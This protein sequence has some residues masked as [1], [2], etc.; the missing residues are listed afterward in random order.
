MIP[1]NAKPN[2]QTL[3]PRRIAIHK[4]ANKSAFLELSAIMLLNNNRTPSHALIID[5]SKVREN[6]V[7]LKVM[8]KQ[9]VAE[10]KK[11]IEK[12]PRATFDLKNR[13]ENSFL[14]S[15]P[16]LDQRNLDKHRD[17]NNYTKKLSKN[18]AD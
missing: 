15:R 5:N 7:Q 17:F 10:L 12:A 11:L 3:R 14:N 2:P 18:L 6:S 1:I 4:N 9:I 16:K 8:K 13:I